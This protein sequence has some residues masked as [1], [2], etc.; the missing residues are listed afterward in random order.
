MESIRRQCAKLDKRIAESGFGRFFR[1]DGSGHSKEVKNT[2]FLS[3]VRA[4]LTT[5]FTMSYVISV[6][7]AILTDSGG[8]C[9]CNDP[10]DRTCANNTEYQDC[11][12]ILN[13][14]L[15]TATTAVS[16]FGSFFFGLITN[17]PVALAPGMGLNAYFAYQVVGYHG[18]GSVSYGLALTAVFTEG[19]I[20]VLLSL[21]GM[22]QW[23][24]RLLPTSLKVAAACGIGL[25]LAEIGLSYNAGIGAIT[26][27]TSTPL[28]LGGCPQQYRNALGECKSH[29]MQNPSLWIAIFCGG[30][31]TAVLMAYKIKSAMIIG[32]LVVSA[33]SWPRSTSFT[34]FPHTP[35]GNVRFDFFKQVV[36]FHP[37]RTTLNALEWDVSAAP[38]HF[39]LALFTFLYVDIID[40]TATL[41][42]MA[43]FSGVVDASTGDFP[44][45]T[46]A[47]CTDA[48]SIAFGSL[49][50]VSPVTAYIESGAGIAEGGR[51]GITAI[52][53]GLCFFIT[54]FF[55]PV[56]AS[57][58]PWATGS[59]VI[60]VGAMMVRQVTAVNWNYIG[61]AV[62]AFVTIIFIPMSYSTAYGVIA[63]ML[64]Y[65]AINVPLYLIRLIT[66]GHVRPV[67]EERR[68]YWSFGKYNAGDKPLC[69]PPKVLK[70]PWVTFASAEVLIRDQIGRRKTVPPNR[71]TLLR[72]SPPAWEELEPVTSKS[73]V[74]A[75]LRPQTRETESR[76]G[77]ILIY[78]SSACHRGT[79]LERLQYIRDVYR[80]AFDQA[81][82]ILA[83]NALCIVVIRLE[84]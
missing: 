61:D 22:R 69:L 5:F 2:R 58:P 32:I 48:V 67:D 45:S 55:A 10:K 68:E 16:A 63:G 70:Y 46:L 53:A 79:L 78:V 43:R 11:L 80:A 7:A 35:D 18:T 19:F 4:G 83:S 64:V 62:P 38:G 37:L 42:S 17:L 23:L 15:I 77:R 66:C 44:R 65:V 3:E 39:I 52:T 26:G 84:V 41:Y 29:K 76:N 47:Y 82:Q 24:V 50:G 40:C 30:V 60:L 28:D 12:L 54:L 36:T 27:A 21:L 56:F 31:L 81:I 25:F 1:L 8:A 9:K 73:N 51:T 72:S 75:P 57:I 33:I 20:F 59:T 71:A 13:R 6:N 74:E 49:V 34:Y 14:D